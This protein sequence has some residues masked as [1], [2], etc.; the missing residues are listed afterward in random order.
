MKH[1]NEILLDVSCD[2]ESLMFIVTLFPQQ[3]E[4][5][6]ALQ[7]ARPY[8]FIRAFA[9]LPSLISLI[10]FSAFRGECTVLDLGR[11]V[12]NDVRKISLISAITNRYT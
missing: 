1:C 8:L 11:V 10:G 12:V 5:A 4:G 2:L 6:P 7:Y 3:I 9:F